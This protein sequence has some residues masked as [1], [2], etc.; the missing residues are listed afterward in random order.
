MA[1]PMVAEPENSTGGEP[2]RWTQPPDTDFLD[3]TTVE[4]VPVARLRPADSPRLGGEDRDYVRTLADIPGLPP[5][6]VHRPTMRVIDGMH[7]LRSATLRGDSHI[8][9]RYFDGGAEQAFVLA[10]KLNVGHGLPLSQ[11]DRR[12]AATRILRTHP[13][14]SNVAVARVS[15]VSDKTVAA[16]RREL[17][18]LGDPELE[19][20]L[21]RD[22][23]VRPLRSA[24]GRRR[25]AAVMTANPR[26]NLREIA[27]ATGIA[28]ATAK[29]VRDRLRCGDDPVPIRHRRG[30]RG[31]EAGAR[32]GDAA[33]RTTR[34]GEAAV[35]VRALRADPSLRSS[36]LGR[37]VLRML[38][39]SYIDDEKWRQIVESVPP[40]CAGALARAANECAEVWHRFARSL[41]AH[42]VGRRG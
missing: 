34:A 25:A 19:R 22:G 13:H 35:A 24:D 31:T 16:V 14:W 4:R 6:V 30:N 27:A 17:F 26:A 12:A 33:D 21:G 8:A 23:R 11:A 10:V 32:G 37:A 36:E 3:H 40:H 15:G 42:M 38:E 7:R 28:L 20:R 39:V 29:D 1:H 5:I 2:E 9:V 41:D 18:N